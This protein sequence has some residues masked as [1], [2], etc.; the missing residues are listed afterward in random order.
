MRCSIR[1][2]FAFASLLALFAGALAGSP[3]MADEFD[4]LRAAINASPLTNVAVIVG[5]SGGEVF[6]Y[7]KHSDPTFGYDTPMQ[8]ASSS[9]WL[10]GMTLMRMIEA[11]E[12]QW[13]DHPQQY[14]SYW[15]SQAPRGSIT[16]AQLLAFQSGFNRIPLLNG[17]VDSASHTVQSCARNIYLGGVDRT[18]GA[19]FSY[20][21]EHLHVAAAMAEKAENTTFN[22]LF[23]TYVTSPLGLTNTQ[24]T[25]ASA[26]NPWVAGG[27]Q[28]TANDFA[29]VLQALLSGGFILDLDT[30]LGTTSRAPGV[31]KLYVPN[32]G[33]NIGDWEFAYSSWVECDA[34]TGGANFNAQ[35]SL[36]KINSAPGSYGWVPWID[37][38]HGYWAVIATEDHSNG[39]GKGVTLEQALQ[40]LIV[41][42]LQ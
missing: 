12:M 6:R 18:P 29:L 8:I 14:L 30:F 5:T 23:S 4:P 1:L 15:T 17:C 27:A 9:K 20:G 3:A 38:Q 37:R 42:A 10:T 31:Q 22:T 19:Y 33:V 34:G 40:P 16:L 2:P 36:D 13:A 32:I 39:V 35:C 41:T 7:V 26:T 21:P 11:G 25:L 28:S 24:F